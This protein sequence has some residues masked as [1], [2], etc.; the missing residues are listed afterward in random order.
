[1]GVAPESGAESGALGAQSGALDPDL[2]A[3]IA[4]WAKLTPT[5]KRVLRTMVRRANNRDEA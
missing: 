1:M 3:I 4:A 5:D 2:Q